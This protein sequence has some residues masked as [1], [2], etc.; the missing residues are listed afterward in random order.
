ML[1]KLGYK[2]FKEDQGF[3]IV[4]IIVIAITLITSLYPFLYMVA[5]SFSDS[6]AV[7]KGEVTLI[8]KGFQFTAYKSV[9]ENDDIL[10]SYLNTIIYVTLGTS[11]SVFVTAT[12]AYAISNPRLIWRKFFTMMIMFT[13]YFGGGMIPTYLVVKWCGLVGSMWSFLLLGAVS[14]YNLIVMRSFFDGLPHELQESAFIDGAN[15][16]H[17]FFK[18]ILPCSKAVVSTMVL[19][20]AVGI[21]NSFMWPY[22][23]LSDEKKYPLQIVL[24]QIVLAGDSRASEGSTDGGLVSDTIKY[25]TIIVSMVPILC[26]YPFVQKYFVKGVMVGSVKG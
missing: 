3:N 14:V 9:L 8:P 22:L 12:G 11:I 17:V 25:A 7:M 20:Y 26:V 13:M 18:I 4:K 2:I 10:R 16:I 24:R 6:M 21:W 19:F 1:K 23:L 5:V 15:D